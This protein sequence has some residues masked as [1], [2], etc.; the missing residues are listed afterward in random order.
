MQW[1]VFQGRKKRYEVVGD[2]GVVGLVNEGHGGG[3]V[4]VS[5]WY[6]WEGGLV[7]GMKALMGTVRMEEDMVGTVKEV[8]FGSSKEH[9]CMDLEALF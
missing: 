2:D 7:L 5:W 1:S 4:A 8:G 9:C 6:E 3:A